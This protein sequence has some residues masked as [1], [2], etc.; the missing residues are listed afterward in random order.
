MMGMKTDF[1][2]IFLDIAKDFQCEMCGQCCKN[3]W[4]VTLDENSYQRNRRVFSER[5][6]TAEFNAAFLPLQGASCPGEYACIAKKES[7]GCWFLE[8]DNRCRLHRE[9][10]HEH[11]DSV[12]MTFPRYP[13][14]SARGVELTLT[15]NCP[16]VVKRLFRNEPLQVLRSSAAPFGFSDEAFVAHVHPEQ[17][18]RND[19]LRHYFA[20]EQ[21]FIDLLQARG[22]S[23]DA[24]LQRLTDTVRRIA[25]GDDIEERLKQVFAANYEA[26]DLLP[27]P[28]TA[29]EFSAEVLQEHFLVNLVFQKIFYLYGLEKGLKLL[30]HF[31]CEM[32]A[33]KAA[34]PESGELEAVRCSIMTLAF[35]HSHNRKLLS[36]LAQEER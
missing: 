10:G 24:R 16:A 27:L 7:G 31:R 4:L 36:D 19:S 11:L 13:I 35:Q 17:M 2:Y 22:E 6:E 26:L 12:C 33:A 23:L 25:A 14:S 8:G 3:D 28:D 9:F 20:L 29:P 15:L 32:Q 18:R 30:L 34:A 5:G 21:H 1:M